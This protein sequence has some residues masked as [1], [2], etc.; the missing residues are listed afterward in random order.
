[1]NLPFYDPT[2]SGG[3]A[4]RILSFGGGKGG[5]GKSFVTAAVAYALAK[6]GIRTLL[7][8]LDLGGANLH[9]WYGRTPL[10]TADLGAFLRSDGPELEELI[11]PGPLPALS[12][13][14]GAS[15]HLGAPNLKYASKLKLMQHLRRLSYDWILLDLAAGSSYNTLDFFL[16]GTRG[17]VVVTPERTS[18]EN[19]YRFLRAALLRAIRGLSQHHGF[20]EAL[21]DAESNVQRAGRLDHLIERLVLIEPKAVE[22][23]ERLLGDLRWSLI[24]N[25]IWELDELRLATH[26]KLAAQR[27]LGIELAFLGPVRYDEGVVRALRRSGTP[28][29]TVFHHAGVREDIE[30]VVDRMLRD[31]EL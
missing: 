22:P 14:F 2:P 8:D 4:A 18:V 5:I 20:Q 13:V 16:L 21:R 26:M 3:F 25:Q 15:S 11:Q 24:L 28:I 7:V 30:S 6:R 1:M 17:N 27:H 12:F 31:T 19:A 23:L 29:E 10:K 9:A